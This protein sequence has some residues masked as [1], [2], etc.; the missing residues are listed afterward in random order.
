MKGAEKFLDRVPDEFVF[1]CHDGRILH[2]MKEL[3]EVLESMSD[4]TFRYHANPEKNDF[5]LWVKDV[6]GD[7]RLARELAKATHCAE[8][9]R[10]VAKRIAF[11]SRQLTPSRA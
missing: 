3:G 10:V 5:S 11:L 1:W 9:A 2:D 6:I 8:A 4:E 7:E